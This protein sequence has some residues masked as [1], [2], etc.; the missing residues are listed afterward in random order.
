MLHW[1]WP[2]IDFF[3]PGVTQSALGERVFANSVAGRK[4]DF[5]G[6]PALLHTYS[7][8][9]DIAEGLASSARTTAPPVRCGTCP[10]RRP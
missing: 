1:L 4:V 6:D 9:P 8:V 3:G 5:L 10:G 2:G 7:Y